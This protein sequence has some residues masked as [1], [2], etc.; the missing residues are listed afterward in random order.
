MSAKARA[1]TSD[2]DANALITQAVQQNPQ[3]QQLRLETLEQRQLLDA[4]LAEDFVPQLEGFGRV[5]YEDRAASRFGGGSETLDATL[6]LRLTVPIFNASGT[7]Y[8]TFEQH[9]DLRAATLSEA[10]LRR[11][12]EVEIRSLVNRLRAQNNLIA[13]A[14]T[15]YNAAQELLKSAYRSVESGVA[16]DLIVLRHKVQLANAKEWR[17][18]INYSYLRNAARLSFVTGKPI[19]L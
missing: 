5:E 19:G 1:Q 9:S 10:Q 7:G 17:S 16:T 13:K 15:A 8:G 14:D 18:R 6:G 4:A 3:A 11:S 2:L 12:L